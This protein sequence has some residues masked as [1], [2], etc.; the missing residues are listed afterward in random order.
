MYGFIGAV[1]RDIQ[2]KKSLI[3]PIQKAFTSA[4][5]CANEIL[6][7]NGLKK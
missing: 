4:Q 1:D 6:I 2:H 7:I 5:F 3:R